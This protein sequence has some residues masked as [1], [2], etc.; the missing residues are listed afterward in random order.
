MKP[1]PLAAVATAA[2]V[3]ALLLAAGPS[4]ARTGPRPRPAHPPT[5]YSAA[6]GGLFPARDVWGQ[7]ERSN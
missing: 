1:S 6:F 7:Y 3:V 2:V 4:A 5:H